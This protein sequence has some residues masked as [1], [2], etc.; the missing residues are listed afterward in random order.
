MLSGGKDNFLYQHVFYD[1]KK[2]A[3]DLVPSG[4]DL[5]VYGLIGHASQVKRGKI[6]TVVGPSG[7]FGNQIPIW[8]L[9][10]GKDYK[11]L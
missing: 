4:V 8:L 6:L 11:C 1:A 5:S 2:P 3:E 9:S 10:I 7:H